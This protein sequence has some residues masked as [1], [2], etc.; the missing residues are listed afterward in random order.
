MGKPA[1]EDSQVKGTDSGTG[2]PRPKSCFHRYWLWA[3]PSELW[4]IG[5]LLNLCLGLNVIIV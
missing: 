4:D 2:L 3:L 5:K 1:V